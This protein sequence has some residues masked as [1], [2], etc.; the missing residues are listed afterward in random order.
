[1]ANRWFQAALLTLALLMLGTA[2]FSFAGEIQPFPENTD[3]DPEVKKALKDVDAPK[4]STPP[5]CTV[6]CSKKTATCAMSCGQ[7]G[8]AKD[9]DD[10]KLEKD[11]KEKKRSTRQLN[12]QDQCH[13][14]CAE[15][16]Q[17][18]LAACK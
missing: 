18:C 6:E 13:Q 1:M 12:K 9:L 7:S 10:K 16:Q 15:Q 2:G 3:D 17:K 11:L 5:P 8:D 4:K 14:K